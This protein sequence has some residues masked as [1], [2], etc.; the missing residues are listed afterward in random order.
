MSVQST[1]KF[2]EQC[3]ALARALNQYEPLWKSSFRSVVDQHDTFGFFDAGDVI[4][5]SYVVEDADGNIQGFSFTRF[6][7]IDAVTMLQQI[8]LF[9]TNAAI[10]VADYQTSLERITNI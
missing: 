9:M 1:Q 6:D 2:N 7:Y 10:I 4:A 5:P 3:Q 8:E